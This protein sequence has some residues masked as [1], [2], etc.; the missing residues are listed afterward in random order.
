MHSSLEWNEPSLVGDL[1]ANRAWITLVYW[2]D[3]ID[4]NNV[5][6]WINKN[7]RKWETDPPLWYTDGWKS[8][9]RLRIYNK[10]YG[11]KVCNRLH[12]K[13][14]A[15]LPETNAKNDEPDSFKLPET[16]AKN[17]GI[18]SLKLESAF[19]EEKWI[20]ENKEGHDN[21][22]KKNCFSLNEIDEKKEG[23]ETKEGHD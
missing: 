5:V 18:D 9:L 6:D 1:D 22:E 15:I 17:N 7:K 16:N 4:L 21:S 19:G 13:K 2:I 12:H 20:D 23:H 8:K 3:D 10:C 14:I 11:K